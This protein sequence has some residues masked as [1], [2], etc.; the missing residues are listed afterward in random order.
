MMPL[1]TVLVDTMKRCS[2]PTLNLVAFMSEDL[3]TV[4]SFGAFGP[5]LRKR[6]VDAGLSLAD[7]SRLIHYSVSHLSKVE[8]GAKPASPDLARRC[9]AALACSGDLQALAPSASAAIG[10]IDGQSVRENHDSTTGKAEGEVW[11]LNLDSTGGS[12]FELSRRGFVAGL[13]G[14][15]L[16]SSP[17]PGEQV[18]HVDSL[19]AFRLMLD[20][21]RAL[22]QHVP[23]EMLIPMLATQTHALQSLATQAR[24]ADRDAALV[25]AAHFADYAGWMTQEAGDDKGAAWWT[26]KA[27][28]YA[29]A[30][31][32]QKMSAYTYVRHA[33]IA[34]YQ[35]DPIRTIGLAQYAQTLTTDRRV[36]ALAAQRE[37]QGH[38]LAG[39]LA[40]CQRSLDRAAEL[41]QRSESRDEPVIGSSHVPDAVTMTFGWCLFDLGRP[42]QAA[43]ILRDQLMR[44]PERAH[45]VRARFA[46][47]MALALA[48]SGEAEE[49][50]RVAEPVLGSFAQL[51]SATIRHDLRGL[52]RELNRWHYHGDTAGLRLRL[53]AALS[54]RTV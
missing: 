23:G 28:G 17:T 27:A 42:A 47:R 44:L 41:L 19:R 33:L 10:H 14:M 38:A 52:A 11:T 3:A 4:S 50:C 1:A 32:D 30:G 9:D 21:L 13:P 25:L 54:V 34:L 53:N 35:H 29:E 39:D 7:L 37:A 48:A 6:R 12:S 45:R 2:R 51:D 22:G 8:T 31:G 24:P 15:W 5:E 20:Q 43:E 46:T 26:G 49:A 18:S 16:A 40:A 36:Q